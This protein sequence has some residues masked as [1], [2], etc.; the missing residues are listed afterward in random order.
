MKL[1]TVFTI[2]LLL[3]MALAIAACTP[4]APVD[5][6]YPAGNQENFEFKYDTSSG[7]SQKT[8]TSTEEYLG[9]VKSFENQG[10][11]YGGI[12][13]MRGG[14]AMEF[15]VA[16]DAVASP[17]AVKSDSQGAGSNGGLDYSG[18]NNQVQNV[19][20][21][22]ILKTD[23]NYIYTITDQTLFIIKAY[24]GEDA[25]VVSTI[26][27]DNTPQGLFVNGDKLAVFGSDY[28]NKA[29]SDLGIRTRSG[30]TYLQI[31]DISDKEKPT[32]EKT[33]RF[34]GQ[35]SNSRMIGNDVYLV[36]TMYPL[37]RIDYPLPILMDGAEV[38][39]MPVDDIRYFNIPYNNPSFIAAHSVN[40][41][42]EEITDSEMLTVEGYPQVYMS[43]DNMYITY[44]EYVNEWELQREIIKELLEP[45]MPEYY[46]NIIRKIE[47]T[48]LD[49]L[50]KPEK[51]EKIMQLYY[52]YMETMP[53]KDQD[54]L[55]DKAEE[56]LKEKLEQYDYYEYTVIN[57]LKVDNGQI[58]LDANG[59]APGQILNQFSMDEHNDVFRIAT[60]VSQ[61]WDRFNGGSTESKNNIYT[62]DEDLEQLGALEGLAKGESIY[63]TRFIDD[64]L[65]MVTFR[66]V[67]PFFVIDLSNPKNPKEL[68]QLKIPGFSRYLHPYDKDTI[69]GIGR[70]ATSTGRQEGLKIS[71][72]D[73]SDFEHPVEI[74]KYVSDD[75]Y[76]SSSAEWE[77]KAFL[78]N[79]EKELLVIPVQN[80]DWQDSSNNYNGALVFKITNNDIELKGL[81]DHSKG[82][83]QYYG[84]GVERSL[85]IED[86]LYTKSPGL[87]RINEIQDLSS[88]KDVTLDAKYAGEIP[89]Y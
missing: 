80:Y 1:K 69:I 29:L 3:I 11:Y 10:G 25:E 89:V 8:F 19:D 65:Y 68:G 67:D 28:N 79:K 75:R 16:E 77:H 51:Q 24:P 9:F 66:Q 78:F 27:L 50:S 54:S 72:F 57:K 40:L 81:V 35:Y 30:M 45:E 84:Q 44:T 2:T 85:Y 22:D 14:V 13:L 42:T 55:N 20:E 86:L 4:S 7:I 53:S 34:E 48:D 58:S 31:Y 76:S 62:F 17:T 52:E 6:K 82:S 43:Q 37:Y 33:L 61:R 47:A 39:Q 64:K 87:L 70:D 18:T 83:N 49:V 23:G 5:P 88:V 63:S 15:A 56:L 59:K 73:V 36:T 71:L 12:G 32:E 74:A 60:T 26:K 41:E 46:K 38:K 21:G